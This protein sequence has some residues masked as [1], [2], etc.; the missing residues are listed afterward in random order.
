MSPS[1]SA[2][3]S[4]PSSSPFSSSSSS[5]SVF[6]L[7]MEQSLKQHTMCSYFVTSPAVPSMTSTFYSSVCK[8][9]LV[10]YCV[11]F[12][13]FHLV[14]S[15]KRNFQLAGFFNMFYPVATYFPHLLIHWN[16]SSS[17]HIF[18]ISVFVILI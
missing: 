8:S 15:R 2:F 7:L 5:S 3:S 10:Y 18:H 9:F 17:L 6:Y 11:L 12:Y 16:L 1:S 14:V 4:S 13:F